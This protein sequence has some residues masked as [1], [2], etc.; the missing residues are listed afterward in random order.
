[1]D[2]DGSTRKRTVVSL[3]GKSK[4]EDAKEL[5]RRARAEREARA[6]EKRRGA[7]AATLLRFYRRRYASRFT[8]A[9]HDSPCISPPHPPN[10]T[11]SAQARAELRAA[12]D[13]KASDLGKLR[14]LLAA[15][16]QPLPTPAATLMEPLAQ[17]LVQFY[18]PAFP[19]DGG[20]LDALA[21]L[22]LDSCRS[23]N[24]Q[25]NGRRAGFLFV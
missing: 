17:S 3:R 20:R 15:A 11:A 22:L 5:L 18:D 7:A 1:M 23:G 4:E 8:P 9:L 19:G 25:V 24:P 10:R 13:R 6:A 2:F 16:G 14:T 12:F 21:R